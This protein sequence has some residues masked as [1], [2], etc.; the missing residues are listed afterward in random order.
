MQIKHVDG[1]F[2]TYHPGSFWYN[3]QKESQCVLVCVKKRVMQILKMLILFLYANPDAV[4]V[5][6]DG[7]FD[8]RY[9][10]SKQLF[11]RYNF[12]V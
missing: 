7:G 4:I 10:S 12:Q 6:M 8:I 3:I 2:D 5:W 9:L 11:D 1:G